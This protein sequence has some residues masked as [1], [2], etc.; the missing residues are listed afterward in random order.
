MKDPIRASAFAAL[1]A[2][3]I[4][5][6]AVAQPGGDAFRGKQITIVVGYGAGGGY[7][8]YARLLGRHMGRHLPGN[9]GF[10]IQNMP[11]AGS[12]RAANYIAN[13]APKDG[14]MLGMFGTPA[15]LEP[16]FGNKGAQF[17]PRNFNWIGNILRDTPAC[18]MWRTGS[19][20]S[21]EEARKSKTQ[22]VFAATGAGSYGNQHALILKDMLGINLRVITGFKGLVDVALALERGEAHAGCGLFVSTAKAAFRSQVERGDMLFLIQFGKQNHPY[23]RG[24]PNFHRLISGE[25][26]RK[27]ADFF[28]G[29][30]EVARPLSAP[31]GVPAATVS[32]LRQAMLDVLRDK[33][34]LEEAAKMTLEI[35]PVTG[36]ETSKEMAAFF[37]APTAVIDR[38]KAILGRK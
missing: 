15:A 28:F 2:A 32:M 4:A 25:D 23:Y 10:V 35:A 12:L 24:A 5:G 1:L 13:V 27:V 11:G 14:T 22:L 9:P 16:L 36:E 29:L 18:I 21:L 7:D 19:V 33:A 3:S 38:A 26:N 30:A 20:K 17:D 8:T 34:L 37:S 31:P 6:N